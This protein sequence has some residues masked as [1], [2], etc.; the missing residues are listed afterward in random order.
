LS[1]EIT[2]YRPI[3][4]TEGLDFDPTPFIEVGQVYQR[5]GRYTAHKKG[6]KPYVDF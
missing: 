3:N 6:G 2:G 4:E 1:Y 5:T